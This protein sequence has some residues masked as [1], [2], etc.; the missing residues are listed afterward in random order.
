[1]GNRIRAR[2]RTEIN[3]P[4]GKWIRG[5]KDMEGVPG[6]GWLAVVV[7]STSVMSCCKVTV[8]PI[9]FECVAR[10]LCSLF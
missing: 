5:C 7:P 3:K 2:N 6:F 9:S 4:E 10:F 1:M 8:S